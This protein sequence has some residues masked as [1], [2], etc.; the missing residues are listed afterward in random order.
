VSKV[1]ERAHEHEWAS[2]VSGMSGATE[3]PVKNEI[4]CD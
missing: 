3:W 4:V 1:S 2:E